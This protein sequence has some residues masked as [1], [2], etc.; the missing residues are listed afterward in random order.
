MKESTKLVDPTLAEIDFLRSEVDTGLT[1]AKIAHNANRDDRK[2][3]NRLNARKAYDAVVRFTP[4]VT[5]T[6]EET[7]EMKTKM[8]QLKSEL[9][10]LGEEFQTLGSV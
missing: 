7:D 9:Q 10:K 3:R 4:R 6:A 8:E 2:S 1:L 5:L